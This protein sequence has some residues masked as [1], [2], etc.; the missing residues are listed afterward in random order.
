M[1]YH[2]PMRSISLIVLVLVA[3]ACDRLGS[4]SAGAAASA[5]SSAS[6]ASSATTTHSAEPAPPPSAA[7][8]SAAALRDVP[9]PTYKG[10]S[11]PRFNFVVDYPTFFT[12][13][14]AP[15]N[16]D[17]QEWRWGSRAKMT[18]WGMNNSDQSLKDLCN[19]AAKAKKG[20]SGKNV[21]K[22]ACFITGKEGGKI[23]WEKRE[24]SSDV[25]Y[26][27]S[28]E[29]DEDIKAPFDPIVTHVSASFKHAK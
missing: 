9:K 28:L 29:Y 26:G 23:F 16:G 19:E 10:Y 15:E 27:L 25:L 17:G 4:Q 8:E 14:P 5:S 12:A 3:A 11:N 6:A 2:G 1:I 18:A 7:Q 13:Q 21:T 22:D 24:L 20:V